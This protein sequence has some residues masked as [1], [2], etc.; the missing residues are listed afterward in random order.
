VEK[1]YELHILRVVFA[2]LGIQHAMR[3]RYNMSSSVACLTVQYVPRYVTNGN[4]FIKK[5]LFDIER[6]LLDI[7]SRNISNSK[8]NSGRYYHKFTYVFM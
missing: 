3:M 1:Q 2:A 6:V 8:K 7:F 5:K 4:I